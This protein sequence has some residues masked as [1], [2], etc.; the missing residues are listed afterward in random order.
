[1]REAKVEQIGNIVSTGNFNNPQ[2]GRIYNPQGLCPALV[3]VTGGGLEAKIL[4][5]KKMGNVNPSNTGMNGNIISEHGLCSTLTTNK[6]EGAKIAVAS[7]RRDVEGGTEQQLEPNYEGVSNSLT[8]VS[9]DNY[10]MEKVEN[11]VNK[12]K[13]RI[14]KLTTLEVFRLMGFSDEDH[15]KCV[16]V[17][18]SNSQL[19]RQAGNSI[20]TNCISLIFEH[21]YKA[22]YDSNYRCFDEIFLAKELEGCKD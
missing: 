15:D 8:T 16:A 17:G 4:E 20:V 3:T 10:V 6:G 19:Y 21:L 13:L 11:I 14:R 12:F 5:V 7:R 1:V 2:R 9:K 22:Q 18:V